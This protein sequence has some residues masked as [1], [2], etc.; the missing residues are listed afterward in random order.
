MGPKKE[1]KPV[2]LEGIYK[3]GYKR[4]MDMYQ[5][6][7]RRM[8][9]DV[10]DTGYFLYVDG[11]HWN[12]AGMLDDDPATGTMKFNATILTYFG[13]DGWVD[14]ALKD[15]KATLL[16]DECPHHNEGCEEKRFL[17]GVEEALR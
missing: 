10:S 7:A 15:M 5:F 12:V 11:Q 9:F 4:Q 6:V 2:N 14:R 17:D 13:D 8:G 1:P 3:E 16:S